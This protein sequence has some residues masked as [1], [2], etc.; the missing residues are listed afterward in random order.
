[1]TGFRFDD[2]T[3]REVFG[4]DTAEDE[5]PER[6]KAYFFKNRAYENIRANLP[7]RI[8]VG[9]KGIGKSALLRMSFLE[10]RDSDILSLWLQPSDLIIDSSESQSFVEKIEAYKTLINKRIYYA[11]L[12]KLKLADNNEDKFNFQSTAKHLVS[13]LYTK[14]VA[15]SG[16]D[17]D[18]ETQR[19]RSRFT[20]EKIVRVYIDDIDRGWS[21]SKE[22]ISNISALMNAAR[23]LTNEEDSTVQIRIGLRSDAY[24]LYRTS[25]EST[26]K[27][28]GNVVRLTWHRHDILVI[29]AL[30]IATYLG[31]EINIDE[32]EKRTQQAI[33]S[34][35]HPV[36]ED[37]FSVGRGHWNNAPIHIVLLSLNRHRPRDLIKLL[38][39]AA[40]EAHRNKHTKISST[41][42]ENVFANYSHG[43]ITDLILEFKSE[44]PDI[45]PLLFNMR[46]TT[47][48][49]KVREKRWR[50]T[51]GELTAKIRNIM[52]NRNFSFTG[53]S[54]VNENA[55]AEFLYKIEFLVAR[56]EQNG[57]VSWV[58]YDQNRMLQSQFVDFGYKW[59]VHPAYRWALQPKTVHEILDSI[60][61]DHA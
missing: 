13:A 20:S 50:Y 41:D 52:S 17:V 27:I 28:E 37:R 24:F 55:L 39:D 38:T 59:E 4:T 32:L 45:E 11:S 47:A 48:Q 22:D 49:N 56:D 16:A 19:L 43:R 35:L 15:A 57:K 61:I 14:L 46:P 29:M 9:H 40:R 6:L 18:A 53:R 26:D 10:D 42:L 31:K 58:H 60:E 44:L 8:L 36:I 2:Y 5:T 30:R 54:I 21:A 33:A 23:D 7:I 25:D 1:M 51:N 34:E 12:D 3:I